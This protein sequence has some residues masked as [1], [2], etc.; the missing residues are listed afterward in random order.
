MSS[1]QQSEH[2]TEL[3]LLHL[4]D[5]H[6]L[7]TPDDTL[8]GFN[9][10]ANLEQVLAQAVRLYPEVDYLLFTGDVS[11]TGSAQSYQIFQSII[12]AYNIPVLCV[13]GNHDAPWQLNK[14]IPDSPTDSIVFKQHDRYS[15]VLMSS[16]VEDEHHGMLDEK[17]LTQLEQ[18][19]HSSDSALNIF[20]I[21]HPP[22][23]IN[24][25]WLDELGL[26]NQSDLL[27]IINSSAQPSILLSGHIHQQLDIQINQLRLL[28][29]PSTC[30]Q[31]ET[32]VDDRQ[33]QD[34]SMAAFRYVKIS[35]PQQIETT[36]HYLA[37]S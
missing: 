18:Y 32:S 12:A 22:V 1:T 8:F 23:N 37:N 14:I 6:L 2:H 13:P 10:R 20:A 33:H 27:Q 30:H 9:T 7:D 3:T 24:S 26:K 36:V 4:T 28:A 31:F 5:T 15:I 34:Q 25:R 29:T 16:F 21:H 11:Q 35:L 19:L 17:C